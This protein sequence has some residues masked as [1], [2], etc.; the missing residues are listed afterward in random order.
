MQC[1]LDAWEAHHRELL[2]F[3][4][5]R[6]G[7]AQAASDLV[8]EVFLRASRLERGLCGIDNRR[9]WLFQVARNLLIDQHRRLRPE[10]PLAPET[11]AEA[12]LAAPADATAPVERLSEC[13]P[14]VLA[15]LSAADR[16]AI[17]LCDIEGLSQQG[18]ADR[19]GLTLPAAKSRIQRARKRL[20]AQL[21]TACQVHFDADGH[22]CCFVPRPPLQK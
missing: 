6:L 9:A 19:L 12:A 14:R 15:E 5:G 1:I 13:L 18:L 2:R 21:V 22:V 10:I 4:A 16:E 8:Q 17:T 20:R 7:D 11:E 3:V